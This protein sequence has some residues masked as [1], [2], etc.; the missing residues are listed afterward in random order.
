MLAP[1]FCLQ[2]SQGVGEASANTDKFVVVLC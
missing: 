1:L 2:L